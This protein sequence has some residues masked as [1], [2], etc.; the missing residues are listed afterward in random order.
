[1]IRDQRVKVD[2]VTIKDPA[3]DFDPE[4]T[5]VDFDDIVIP[6]SRTLYYLLNKPKNYICSTLDE[7]YPSV[8]NLLPEQDRN[9]LRIIGRLDA[10]TTGVLLLTDDGKLNNYLANPKNHIGKTYRVTLNHEIPLNLPERLLQPVDIGKGEY[11]SPSLLKIVEP[12]VGL[13]T[14]H[15]GKYHEVKRIFHH[16]SLEVIELDRV[17][18]HSFDYGELK[19][20]E[21]RVVEERELEEILR[22]IH[23][24]NYR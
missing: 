9:R 19:P 14:I 21:W 23:P 8:L 24:E 12:Q 5:V 17:K 4:K 7:L 16:F 3:F 10:D 2:G 15:E 6:Y 13:L 1:M 11:S 22:V 20:G 18:F